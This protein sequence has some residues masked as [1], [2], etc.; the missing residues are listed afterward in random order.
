MIAHGLI[1][2]VFFPG[3]S[4]SGAGEAESDCRNGRSTLSFMIGPTEIAHSFDQT[5]I[6][7]SGQHDATQAEL[8]RLFFDPSM[9]DEYWQ[10]EQ[11]LAA[12]KDWMGQDQARAAQVQIALAQAQVGEADIVSAL[13]EG[14]AGLMSL[15]GKLAARVSEA[16]VIAPSD[17]AAGPATAAARAAALRAD[18]AWLARYHSSD[19]RISQAASNELTALNRLAHG[20]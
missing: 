2:P 8:H 7:R 5:G 9:R 12:V 19:R 4:A 17:L 6:G 16:P 3:G 18:P 11:T 20:G 14:P 1:P 15:I 10:I 13:S